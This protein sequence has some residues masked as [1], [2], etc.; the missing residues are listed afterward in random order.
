M[1]KGVE[2]LCESAENTL[3]VLKLPVTPLPTR[4]GSGFI[5]HS[6]R[7]KRGVSGPQGISVTTVRVS[8]D[9][10]NYARRTTGE[11]EKEEGGGGVGSRR[12][13]S[14]LVVGA[15]EALPPRPNRVQAGTHVILAAKALNGGTAVARQH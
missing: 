1:P 4:S 3:L 12:H 13:L 9:D 6:A 7:P 10:G 14:H 2:P 5:T 15:T 11:E 8:C